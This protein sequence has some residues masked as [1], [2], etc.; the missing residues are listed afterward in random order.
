MFLC[1]KYLNHNMI[2]DFNFQ[3]L[4]GCSQALKSLYMQ[5]NGIRSINTETSFILQNLE[6]LLIEINFD[7]F[8]IIDSLLF[9]KFV[10]MLSIRYLYN[11]LMNNL[12]DQSL[13]TFRRVKTLT[14]NFVDSGRNGWIDLSSFK[15]LNFLCLKVS[16]LVSNNCICLVSLKSSY[17]IRLLAGKFR[18]ITGSQIKDS[19]SFTH[20]P[21][22][23]HLIMSDLKSF[24]TVN[25]TKF[26]GL[27][28]LKTLFMN[29]GNI[30]TIKNSS[31]PLLPSLANLQ[32]EHNKIISLGDSAFASMPQLQTLLLSGNFLNQI[33][34]NQFNGL[35]QLQNL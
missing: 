34:V 28:K 13:M 1:H 35:R 11:N 22:L 25:Y 29:N 32:L 21:Q 31:F 23:I 2:E 6:I 10:F 30:S 8:R 33:N 14:L 17:N 12:T 19:Y 27:R 3:S 15:N 5:S 18:N 16:I 20:H 7:Y 4:L 9:F 26:Q 24:F